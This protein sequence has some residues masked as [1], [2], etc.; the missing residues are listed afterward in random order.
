MCQQKYGYV[1]QGGFY[2]QIKPECVVLM[3]YDELL[4]GTKISRHDLVRIIEN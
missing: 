3:I 2:Q 1:N 4:D